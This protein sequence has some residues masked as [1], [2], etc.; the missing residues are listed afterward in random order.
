MRFVLCVYVCE[1]SD[2]TSARRVLVHFQ[3]CRL[4]I[5]TWCGLQRFFCAV[6]MRAYVRGLHVFVLCAGLHEWASSFGSGY[7]HP[8]LSQYV[9]HVQ[10][11]SQHQSPLALWPVLSMCRRAMRSPL[12]VLFAK[13]LCG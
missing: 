12:N 11:D 1:N 10:I 7:D 13:S 2:L 3:L 4:W 6:S 5:I 9:L 8:C